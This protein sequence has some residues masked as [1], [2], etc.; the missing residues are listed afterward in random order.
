M[1]AWPE[2]EGVAVPGVKTDKSAG[3]RIVALL[4]AAAWLAWGPG[5]AS[6]QTFVV[7][8]PAEPIQLDPAVAV[9]SASLQITRQLY[10]TLMS[11]EGAP[12]EIRPGLAE[13]WEASPDGTVWTF[14]LRR[15]VR[16]HD[17]TPLD[18]AA[19]VWNFERWRRSDHPQHV[20]QVRAGRSFEYW[21]SQFGGFAAAAVVSKVEAIGS[22]AVRLTLRSPLA[23]LLASLAMPGFGIASPAAVERWGTEFGRH[24]VGT[25]AFR[26]VGWAPGQ[27]VVLEANPDH[28]GVKPKVSRVVA[29]PIKDNARRLAAL[30]AGEI[31][32]ME[33]LNPDD[34]R[35]VAADPGLRLL[36]R[37]E[38][39]TGY[40][41]F[42]YR[43][44][45]FRDRRVRLAFAHAIDK[46][47]IVDA[48]YGGTGLA[49]TQ[50]QPPSLWGH[51]PGLRDHAHSPARARELL[52][53]AGFPDGLREI[54]WEDGGREPLV[55][56]Y[57]P[58]SRPYFPNPREIAQAIAADLARAGIAVR[59]KTVDWA[60]YL[61]RVKNGRLPLYMLGWIGDNGDP[62][63]AL[64][65]VF[66]APGAAHQ[67]FYTNR[68]LAD[69]LRRARTLPGDGER[70]VLYRRAER[71]LHEDV[72]RLFIA[73]NRTPLALARG[74]TGYL[75]SLTGAEPFNTVEVR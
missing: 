43:V 12:A 72:A 38:N 49:A 39:N 7:G 64:C 73:H 33:G 51:D 1:I 74:V 65:A 62:D 63:H 45:G 61:D 26:L 56:W 75:P 40:L 70:A 47:A 37:P 6:V 3:V 48:L 9:D 11:L 22:H 15:G 34:V 29:R 60:V 36:L 21:S 4:V 8:L 71:L 23:P 10:D 67:G 44:R 50:F 25:G 41:A 13:R 32:A 35:A 52:R 57:M 31:H 5:A 53:Q 66:C 59:L 27:D 24:P 17:G 54:T 55:L 69:L 58:V 42:N 68:A 18:A 46:R 20:N 14:H 2:R 19:V 16:F 30:K 28:W